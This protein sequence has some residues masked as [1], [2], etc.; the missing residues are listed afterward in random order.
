MADRRR[1][2]APQL[3]PLT[4]VSVDKHVVP[5]IGTDDGFGAEYDAEALTAE[6]G[7]P[8]FVVSERHLRERFRVFLDAFPTPASTRASPIPTRPTTSARSAPSCTR[9]APGPRSS[10]ASSCRSPST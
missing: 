9:K 8:L 5:D 2:A 10:R 1:Y 4:Y 6:F 3:V 7:S